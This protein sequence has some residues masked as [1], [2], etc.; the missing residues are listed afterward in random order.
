MKQKAFEK[1]R[2]PEESKLIKEACYFFGGPSS[3][4]VQLSALRLEEAAAAGGDW[5]MTGLDGQLQARYVLYTH[6]GL[7]RGNGGI[8][9]VIKKCQ[10][11]GV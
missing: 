11:R 3:R 6:L 1:K 10:K 8:Y 2:T 4:R 9:D 5:E 7:V